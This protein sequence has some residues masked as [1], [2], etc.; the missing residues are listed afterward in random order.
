MI[1]LQVNILEINQKYKYINFEVAKEGLTPSVEKKWIIST[2]F[3]LYTNIA[4]KIT[5]YEK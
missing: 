4:R 1:N 5:H 2:N 3:F